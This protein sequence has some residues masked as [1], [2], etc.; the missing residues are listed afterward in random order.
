MKHS[1][2]KL[3]GAFIKLESLLKC[4]GLVSTG[5]QAKVFI[6]NSEVYVNNEICLQRGKKLRKGDIVKMFDDEIEIC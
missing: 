4:N 5:G 2:F 6:Q 3:D 1:K